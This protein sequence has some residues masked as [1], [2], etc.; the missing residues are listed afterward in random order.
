MLQSA[1]VTVLLRELRAVRRSLEAY[2]DDASVWAERPGLPN[3]GGTL[4]LHLAGNLRH[5]I[6]LH[7]G[8][9]PYVRDRDA[10][11]A[12][13]GV[14]RA[15]L[16]AGIDAAMEAVERGMLAT[17]D[18]RMNAPFPEPIGGRRIATGDFLVHLAVH[19][20]WHLG[21]LDYHR[22]IVTGDAQGVGAVAPAELAEAR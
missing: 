22:R 17:T 13:R 20:A 18:D 1:V 4:A 11:F 7:L 19:L 2:P 8:G 5:F 12:R 16:I 21:Q 14:P 15:E 3:A 9:V 6:G 10:E